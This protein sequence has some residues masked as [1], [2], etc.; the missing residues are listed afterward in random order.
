[1][2]QCKDALVALRSTLHARHSL[3]TRHNKNFC[4][5]KQNTRA[6]EAAHRLDMKCKLAVLKYNMA[7]NAL[8]ILQGPGDWEQTLHEL[9]TS[10][11]VSLHRSVLEIDSSSE[12]EDSQPQGEGHKE[13]SWIWM[14]EG[15]LSD[16]EDEALNQAVKL[17]WLKSRARS[18]RW[19]EEGILV[20]EEM[21]HTLLSLE[22]QAHKWRGLG[23][24]WE[25]L[26]PAGTEGVQAYAAHQVILYQCLGIHFRT[27]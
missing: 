10:D 24:E 1:E 2:A 19:R 27:L 3:F 15:A 11:C 22:W 13:V 25:D 7:Q 21:C 4:G 14:Q 6:A 23:S 26:D 18:M 17:K 5:Q 12:E 16:G 8:L 9:W 20:E